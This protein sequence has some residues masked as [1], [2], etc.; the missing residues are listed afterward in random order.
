MSSLK[1]ELPETRTPREPLEICE[2]EQH[3]AKVPQSLL[4][5][6]LEMKWGESEESI[7]WLLAELGFEVIEM[8][9]RSGHGVIEPTV[10]TAHDRLPFPS[11]LASSTSSWNRAV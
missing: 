4:K 11:Y 5:R 10:A 3:K 6:L 9:N 8:A 7:R 1:P 2:I